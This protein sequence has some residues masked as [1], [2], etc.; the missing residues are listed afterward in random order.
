MGFAE[1]S[2]LCCLGQLQWS[3]VSTET[4][5][6]VEKHYIQQLKRLLLFAETTKFNNLL[7][8]Y[9]DCLFLS[10]LDTI[11]HWSRFASLFWKHWL[12]L[13]L[14]SKNCKMSFSTCVKRCTLNFWL[15]ML[16][17]RKQ[18][19]YRLVLVCHVVEGEYWRASSPHAEIIFPK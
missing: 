18:V 7:F 5:D 9:C 19:L 12:C 4:W 2:V 16:N 1:L 17:L 10:T 14:V 11:V 6:Q 3:I 13:N 8:N 15:H